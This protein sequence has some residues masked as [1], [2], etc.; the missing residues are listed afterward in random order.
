LDQQ[1]HGIKTFLGNSNNYNENN[2]INLN[3]NISESFFYNINLLNSSR[4]EAIFFRNLNFN[5]KVTL[6][7]FIKF[8]VLVSNGKDIAFMLIPLIQ[9]F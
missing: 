8:D 2:I 1:G 4:G 5:L 9:M 3:F 7:L 6:P